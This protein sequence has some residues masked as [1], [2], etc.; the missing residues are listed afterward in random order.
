MLISGNCSLFQSFFYVCYSALRLMIF[1][2]NQGFQWSNCGLPSEFCSH[3]Y[4]LS[5]DEIYGLQ[6]EIDE[7]VD[8]CCQQKHTI[9]TLNS[10]LSQIHFVKRQFILMFEIV[11]NIA[12]NFKFKFGD[13]QL[14]FKMTKIGKFSKCCISI[15]FSFMG[16]FI[17]LMTLKSWY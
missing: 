4:E 12:W 11:N 10:K 6:G 5:L 14:L 15:S 2:Q 16:I 1:R 17:V 7:L 9:L 3:Q 13:M 8:E